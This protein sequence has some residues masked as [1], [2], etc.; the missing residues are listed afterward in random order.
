MD[1]LRAARAATTVLPGTWVAIHGG[2]VVGEG[3]TP[4]T[5]RRAARLG[6]C[7]EPPSSSRCEAAGVQVQ[8]LVKASASRTTAAIGAQALALHSAP[9]TLLAAW[10]SRWEAARTDYRPVYC[11]IRASGGRSMMGISMLVST[12]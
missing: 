3:P 1:G 10:P 5:A 9:W 6:G 8:A 11:R 12:V 7:A 2:T 4:G